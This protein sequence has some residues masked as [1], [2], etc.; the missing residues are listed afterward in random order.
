M[1]SCHCVERGAP[2]STGCDNRHGDRT[3]HRQ[4]NLCEAHCGIDVEVDGARC[5]GSPA[6]PRTSSRTG[7]ICPKAAALAD[8]YTDPDRLPS[9]CAASATAG[10]RWGGTRR[11]TSPR[12]GLRAVQ[13]RHGSDAVATYLGN[14]SAH[15]WRCSS[16]CALRARARHAATTTRRR[17]P[18]SCRSTSRSAEMF[19]NL[20]L[21]PI[22]DIDRTD[23]MLVLGANPAV[24]NGSLMTAPG[25]ARPAARDHR[26]AAARSWSSTRAAPRPPSSPPSTSRSARAATP[27]CC[28]GMLQ[29]A[30]R[31]GPACDRARSAGH[32]RRPREIAALAAEW[33]AERAPRRS[34]ASTRRRSSGWRASSRP[35]SGRSRTGAS[36]SASS[37]PARSRTG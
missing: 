21:F 1:V 14:P 37:G 11:S 6:T 34:R 23:H 16:S 33:P 27:T 18:T 17:R 35:P 5:C 9:R 13:R 15:T 20:A 25:R 31:R 26:R 24:S 4:C 10:S 22:P 36:A 2:E 28:S 30:V 19:G 12:T 32:A 3:V 8:L 7:Y 29:R